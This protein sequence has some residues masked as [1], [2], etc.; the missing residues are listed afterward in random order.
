MRVCSHSII[1][2]LFTGDGIFK[3]LELIVIPDNLRM[4]P[5]ER[6]ALYHL[7]SVIRFGYWEEHKNPNLRAV[8][9]LVIE[10]DNSP[11]LKGKN[12]RFLTARYVGP[13]LEP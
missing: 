12:G 8:H 6:V 2:H 4:S 3:G 10:S 11:T 1:A 9:K 5:L 13:N 7:M